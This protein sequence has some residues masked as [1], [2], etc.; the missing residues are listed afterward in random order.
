[1]SNESY[2]AEIDVRNIVGGKTRS[3]SREIVAGTS[4]FVFDDDVD[5]SQRSSLTTRSPPNL[6]RSS[7]LVEEDLDSHSLLDTSNPDITL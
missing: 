3:A 1:M 2:R 7:T 5:I 6:R 4:N